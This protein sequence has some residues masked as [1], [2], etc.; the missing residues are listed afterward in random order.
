MQQFLSNSIVKL[1]CESL[2]QMAI[3]KKAIL[4]SLI[5]FVSEIYWEEAA[6]KPI[7]FF[8]KMF[9]L[10]CELE[11]YA[12]VNQ[13]TKTMAKATYVSKNRIIGSPSWITLSKLDD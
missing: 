5:V 4:F 8:F 12:F 7:L 2:V 6:E 9:V 11:P 10:V 1:D 3:K 13:L